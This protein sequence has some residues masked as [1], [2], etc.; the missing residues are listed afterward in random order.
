MDFSAANVAIWNPVLQISYI[1]I[2]ILIANIIRRKVP[3]IRKSMV[4]T[5]VIAGFI[6]LG[7]KLSGIVNV[8]NEFMETI[9]YHFIAIGFIALSLRVPDATESRGKNHV[10]LRS[11]ATIV[12]TYLI[13]AIFGL[14]IA[15]GLSLTVMPKFFKPAGILLC[16]GFGQ[17]PG[18]ANNT[19]ATYELMWDF[20]GGRS[21]GLSIAAAGYLCACIVGV[22]MLNVLCRRGKIQVLD[23]DELSGSV[24]VDTFQ[25]E[26]EIPVSE[27]IDRL[28]IQV[29]LIMVV[30]LITYLA[31]MG[32]TDALSAFAP[33][34]GNLLNGLLWGFNFI[35]ASAFAVLT[36]MLLKKMNNAN[37][38]KH[39]YQNNY[40]L[41]RISGV[42]FDVMIVA[43]IGS[44]EPRDISGLVLPF[45]LMI[46][47][48]AIVTF[49]N[50][51]FI[52]KRLYKDY[53][54]EGL[55]SMYGMMTGTIS[56]GILLLR[57]IDPNMKTPAANNLVVGS[58]FAILFGAPLL[59]CIG[60]APKSDMMLGIVLAGIVI[61][62]LILLFI[63][64]GGKKCVTREIGRAHV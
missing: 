54:Y 22:I 12:S 5:A 38:V 15:I 18:Q 44:I 20:V 46:I 19:G 32:V 10:G 25:S 51:R 64:I 24:T 9:T 41:S 37:L 59:V 62:Y 49:F 56:S 14:L 47:A 58:T 50:L 3:A 23:H 42:A 60:L 53:Y 11:G 16:L 4:P 13:Q 35:I 31:T 33:A 29:A 8:D 48:G 17:G 27:S 63:A 21:F 30:Y 28:S 7:L 61:Y 40:L 6:M 55:L 34:V 52:C 39:Q 2:M 1:A 57:E 36:R 45:V 43:G 26:K